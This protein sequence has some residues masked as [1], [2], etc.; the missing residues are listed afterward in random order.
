[1]AQKCEKGVFQQ[2]NGIWGYR[3]SILIDGR[4]ISR[5][6]T[7]DEN[8]KSLKTQKQALK[9]REIAIKNAHLEMKKKQ[10]ISRRT[11]KEVFEEYCEKGR[12]DRK[13]QTIRK[14]DSLWENHLCEKFGK[15]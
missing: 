7:T 10:I 11:V 8:G 5:K 13:Y 9:A 12:T 3:F 14:Q 2:E 15:R 1:M 4:R 6:K